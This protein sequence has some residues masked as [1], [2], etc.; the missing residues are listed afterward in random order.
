M[1]SSR[2]CSLPGA[3]RI[4]SLPSAADHGDAGGVIA[5]I[6]EA[7]QAIQDQGNNFLRADVTDNSAHRLI[8]SDV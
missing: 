4:S 7:P 6:F 2:L 8:S 3:R 5:A 1:T